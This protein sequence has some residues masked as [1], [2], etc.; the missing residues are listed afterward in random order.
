MLSQNSTTYWLKKIGREGY[1]VVSVKNGKIFCYP[2]E[3]TDLHTATTLLNAFNTGE[4]IRSW[5]WDN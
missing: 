5:I 2:E 4:E 3:P 1:Q